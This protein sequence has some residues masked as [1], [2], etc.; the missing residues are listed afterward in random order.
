LRVKLDRD[1]IASGTE[2]RGSLEGVRLRWAYLVLI[3]DDGMVQDLWMS[4]WGVG[5]FWME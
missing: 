3:D 2:L 1:Q 4:L 5:A